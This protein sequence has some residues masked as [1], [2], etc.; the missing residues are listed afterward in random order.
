ML[1]LDRLNIF[2]YYHSSLYYDYLYLSE[3]LANEDTC[4]FKK[5]E[6]HKKFNTNWW[7]IRS[8]D[9]VEYTKEEVEARSPE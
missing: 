9:L 6:A 8:R 1:V 7:T 4:P 3:G 2:I 5:I